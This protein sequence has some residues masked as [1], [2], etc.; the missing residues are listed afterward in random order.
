MQEIC[1]ATRSG[2]ILGQLTGDNGQTPTTAYYFINKKRSRE[3]TMELLQID[4]VHGV[5]G[6]AS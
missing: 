1:S 3:P 4:P 2:A 6:V 5:N